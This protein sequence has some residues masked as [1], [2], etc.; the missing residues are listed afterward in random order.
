MSDHRL[1]VSG[2]LEAVRVL[3][4]YRAYSWF[5]ET[6][7]GVSDHEVEVLSKDAV[8]ELFLRRLQWR[9][10]M[11]FFVQ[12][13]ALRAV[14]RRLSAMAYG[15][16]DLEET[17][18]AANRGAGQLQPGWVVRDTEGDTL[19][20]ERNGVRMRVEA[21]LCV[22]DGQ[23]GNGDGG[24]SVRLPKELYARS[25]GHYMALG[26]RRLGDSEPRS[27]IYW[28][29]TPAQG[30]RCMAH[31]T[32]LF[33][34]SGLPFSFKVLNDSSAYGRC[35]SGVLYIHRADL[36][37]AIDLARGLGGEILSVDA[38]P[39][40]LTQRLAP[41]LGFADDTDDGESFGLNRCRLIAE[42][43]VE[44]WRGGP[45]VLSDAVDAVAARFEVE[46]LDLDEPFRASAT[47][48]RVGSVAT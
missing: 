2:V 28:N 38:Q 25:P 14:D 47:A 17:L 1:A 11:D 15:R 20:V 33:N 7:L 22:R 9:L 34:S 23:S 45:P 35:D 30:V 18:S 16:C 46:G 48:G 19:V 26:D 24:A 41:G 42:A 8:L 13:R 44:S 6:F 5:G 36:A 31:V 10:Y 39:P 40:A 4:G 12:G 27:R 3:P 37:D 32:S 43:I 21:H 29:M